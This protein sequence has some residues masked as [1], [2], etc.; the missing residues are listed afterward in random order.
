LNIKLPK[1]FSVQLNGN[2]ESDRIIPQGYRKGISFM[3]F[4]VKKS[5][6]GGAANITFSV[7]DVFNSRRE[8]T[9]YLFP[10]YYQENMRRRDLRYYKLSLQMPFGKMDASIFKRAKEG[11]KQQQGQG[12]MDFG[13]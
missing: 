4:A 7:N 13:G 10:T 11:R 5:F 12:D 3:D 2:Y 1:S 9:T 8:I 6:F